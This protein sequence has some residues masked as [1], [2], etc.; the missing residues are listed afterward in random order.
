MPGGFATTGG[1]ILRKQKVRLGKADLLGGQFL[2]DVA[3]NVAG[4]D[5]AD[6]FFFGHDR[7]V[8]IAAQ[9]HAV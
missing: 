2:G 4:R 1:V 5:H 6:E 8:A 9:R 3:E 7:D